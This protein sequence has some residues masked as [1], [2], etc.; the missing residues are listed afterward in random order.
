LCS[1]AVPDKAVETYQSEVAQPAQV[2]LVILLCL[3]ATPVDLLQKVVTF[4]SVPAQ[5]WGM[6]EVLGVIWSYLVEAVT[7][8]VVGMFLCSVG[9]VKVAQRATLR[10]QRLIPALKARVVLFR[11]QAVV[12]KLTTAAV[13]R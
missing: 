4:E 1:P 11:S 6:L 2:V 8:L 3:L 12:H 7:L 5:T 9:L 13:S 10:L